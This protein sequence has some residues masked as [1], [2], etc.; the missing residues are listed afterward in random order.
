MLILFFLRTKACDFVSDKSLS[1][2][3]KYLITSVDFYPVIIN[4]KF[5]LHKKFAV[6]GLLSDLIYD[7]SKGLPL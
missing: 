3:S 4:N 2:H 7:V 1:L 6:R 5:K